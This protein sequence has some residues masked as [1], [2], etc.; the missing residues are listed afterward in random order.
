M[1]YKFAKIKMLSFVVSFHMIG[2]FRSGNSVCWRWCRWDESGN[3]KR[4]TELRLLGGIRTPLD[5][6]PVTTYSR[7]SGPLETFLVFRSRAARSSGDR[8]VRASLAFCPHKLFTFRVIVAGFL[9]SIYSP[10]PFNN[11]ILL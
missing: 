5:S 10:R 7:R 2:F 9:L 4:R 1:E 3:I 11:T 8:D 6:L